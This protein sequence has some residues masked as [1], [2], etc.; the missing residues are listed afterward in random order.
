MMKILA[1]RFVSMMS[2]IQMTP[3]KGNHSPQNS[4]SKKL[5]HNLESQWI[6]VTIGKMQMVQFDV[7]MMGIQMKLMTVNCI[8]KSNKNREF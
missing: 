3:T 7:T 1:A 4:A 8:E 2:L 6:Q 5:Q